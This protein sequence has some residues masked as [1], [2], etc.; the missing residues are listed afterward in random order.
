MAEKYTKKSIIAFFAVVISLSAVAEFMI[1]KYES[2]VFYPILMWIPALS[3][4]AASVIAITDAKKGFSFKHLLD[5]LGFHFCNIKYIVL[6]IVLPLLYLL[7]PYLIYWKMRPENFAYSG[8]PLKLILSDCLLPLVLGVFTGLLT[9]LGEE[10]G[11]RGFLV[12]ALNEKIGTKKMLNITGLFWCLWHF[13]L[14]IWGGYAEGTPLVYALPAFVLCIF[15]IAVICA[16]LRLKSGSVW[17]CAFLHAAHNNYDQS[18][19]GVITRGADKSF[20]VSE[21][22]VFT[23]V[24][25]WVIAVIMYFSYRKSLKANDANE[26]S[27]Q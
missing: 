1:C 2:L 23:I 15:P 22:G 16:V 6:G 9:A 13:P 25:V 21:T 5:C 3:A 18:V 8:V 12:P 10:I 19:F 20:Y 4:V 24:C 17:P 26:S 27:E 7:V 14:I 11:W